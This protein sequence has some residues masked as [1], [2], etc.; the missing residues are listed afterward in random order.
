M[1][2]DC[3][4]RNKG[5]VWNSNNFSLT[6]NGE[7]VRKTLEKQ[8]YIFTFL[9]LD[10]SYLWNVNA[11]GNLASKKTLQLL[12]DSD[13]NDISN[14][15]FSADGFIQDPQ[16]N[17]V[18]EAIDGEVIVKQK[19]TDNQTN[20]RQLWKKGCSNFEGYFLIEHSESQRLLTVTNDTINSGYSIVLTGEF[21]TLLYTY[22][23][24]TI[25]DPW[26]F[27]K[28]IRT[29]KAHKPVTLSGNHTFTK[30]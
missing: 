27:W 26:Y 28:G 10:P 21:K 12:T 9:L 1:L 22:Y 24:T 16:K 5:N 6:T 17:Y 20:K 14:F 2:D 15:E 3:K 4:L 25:A 30:V 8:G 29:S 19:D 7:L 13:G 18:L 11:A 23:L